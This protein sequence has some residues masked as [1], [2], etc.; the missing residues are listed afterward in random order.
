MAEASGLY[1]HIPFCITRCGYCAF[2]SMAGQDDSVIKRFSS[3]LLD[4]LTALV[5]SRNAAFES[6]YIG[7]GNPALL[8]PS[9]LRRVVSTV[10]SLGTVKEFSIEMNPES[11][12]EDMYPIFEEGVNRLS[13]GIQSLDAAHL[14]TLERSATVEATRQAISRMENIHRKFGTSLSTDLMTCI[15]GQSVNSSLND[16]RILTESLPLSHL[17]LYNLT[18]EEGTS[19]LE[20]REERN[21]LAKEEEEER[22]ILLMLWS[23]LESRGFQQYEISNFSTSRKSRCSH[24]LL[25]WNNGRYHAIGPSAVSLLDQE[26]GLTRSTG[27]AD[28]HAY[29][30]NP[31]ARRYRSEKL[32]KADEMSEYILSSLRTRDGISFRYFKNHFSLDFSEHFRDQITYLEQAVPSMFSLTP[33]SLS[34]SR[35]GFLLCDSITQVFLEAID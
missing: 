24:N 3:L 19:L 32:G 10:S 7:G 33:D 15:P 2:Y 26:D 4:E 9:D 18:Y 14:K 21:I 22:E 27:I 12:N 25:Y 8:A 34:L 1:I 29:M 23:D 17:S 31:L 13:V 16:I 28:L 20:R 5:R 11:L 35:E 30:K 6:V